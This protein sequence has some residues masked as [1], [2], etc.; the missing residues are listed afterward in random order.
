MRL[1]HDPHT[2][3]GVGAARFLEGLVQ[4]VVPET[5]T[6]VVNT[7]D[8]FELHGLYIAPD[9]DI[10]TCT[11]AGLID[12]VQGWGIVGD[13]AECMEW[14]GKLGGPTWF[15]L[16]DRDLALHIRRTALLRSGWT[17]SAVA[18]SF[19]QSLGVTIRILPMS[20]TPVPTH[21]I[22]SVGEMHFEEYFV[23]RRAADE[24]LAVRSVGIAEARPAPGV[25]EA[26]VEA[27]AILLA[28]SNPI[29]SI[30]P[31]IGIPGVRAALRETSAPIVA[32]SPIVGGAAIKGPAVPL[33]RAS[34]VEPTALGIA[35]HYADFL[36]VLVIDTVDAAL[37]PA[38]EALGVRAV[39]T[40][41]IMHGAAEKAALARVALAAARAVGS[42][43]IA[44]IV[45]C[46]PH[47]G[48]VI[49]SPRTKW[50][51]TR[52]SI[53]DTFIPIE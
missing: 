53:D 23:Q 22:T 5:I 28:P 9:L 19:R 16:G 17:L 37:A 2:C 48:S 50:I 3:G 26:I 29:V 33:M 10:V 40:D 7:G 46:S 12:Q 25:L 31:I 24:V 8:D 49:C 32:V 11:L 39:V 52:S 18:D 47:A 6:A 30:G 45:D 20:D 4:I 36:D 35:G 43:C 44:D 1:G 15:K 34:G 21:I 51:L 14:L 27:E 38:I 41:T 42:G 13:T